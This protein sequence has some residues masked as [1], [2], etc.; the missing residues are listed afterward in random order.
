MK[1]PKLKPA[2]DSMRFTFSSARFVFSWEMSIKKKSMA[3]SS[4][5]SMLSG[6]KL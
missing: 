5:L 1:K 6:E 4:T 3:R 2:V